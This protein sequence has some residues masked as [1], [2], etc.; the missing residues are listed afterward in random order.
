MKKIFITIFL[1]VFNGVSYSEEIK[2][3]CDY[4]EG[5]ERTGWEYGKTHV[6]SCSLNSIHPI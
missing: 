3:I 4:V 1:I 2:I 6:S 5:S